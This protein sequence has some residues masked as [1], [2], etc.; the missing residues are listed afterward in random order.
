M[1]IIQFI[2]LIY[3]LS[4]TRLNEG[5]RQNMRTSYAEFI[6][7]K[8][9]HVDYGARCNLCFDEITEMA[10]KTSLQHYFLYFQFSRSLSFYFPVLGYFL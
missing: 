5:Q 3:G 8:Y 2:S 6:H 7:S 1:T 4:K 10:E 9:M